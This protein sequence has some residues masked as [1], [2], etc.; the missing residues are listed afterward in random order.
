MGTVTFTFVTQH[1]THAT[2][3]CSSIW[4]HS[5]SLHLT[6]SSGLLLFFIF[7]YHGFPSYPLF[8]D[9]FAIS[10]KKT[11]LLPMPCFFCSWVSHFFHLAIYRPWC[12]NKKTKT[13]TKTWGFQF[14][15]WKKDKDGARSL[16]IISASCASRKWSKADSA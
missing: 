15:S 2:C 4:L 10:K 12:E 16:E 9:S 1:K 5:I 3:Y 7:L 6:N 8:D 13:K 14:D 11:L